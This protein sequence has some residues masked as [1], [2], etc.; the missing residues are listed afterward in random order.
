[1]MMAMKG[2]NPEEIKFSFDVEIAV[3][4]FHTVT[5]HSV[6]GAKERTKITKLTVAHTLALT[7]L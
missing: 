4:F 5:L 6:T 2:F 3:Q 1:M 7:F